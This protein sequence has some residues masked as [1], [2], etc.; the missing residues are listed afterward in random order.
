[1]TMEKSKYLLLPI[2]SLHQ[3]SLQD[4]GMKNR[5]EWVGN[6]VTKSCLSLNTNHFQDF[7][8][9]ILT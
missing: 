5:E 7:A 8:M 4:S 2:L 6:K 3:V 1:M 9:K